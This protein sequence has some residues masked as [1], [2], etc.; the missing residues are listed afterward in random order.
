MGLLRSSGFSFGAVVGCGCS[1]G[2]LPGE[3]CLF[4]PFLLNVPS[5]PCR[6]TA[7]LLLLIATSD[8]ETTAVA[9]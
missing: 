8:E 4:F 2:S 5:Q 7:Q 6:L 1:A 9:A 3:V